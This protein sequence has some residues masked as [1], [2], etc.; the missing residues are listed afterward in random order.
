[1]KQVAS[2]LLNN[3]WKQN[4]ILHMF[5]VLIVEETVTLLCILLVPVG[6]FV[7]LFF[8]FYIHF[9]KLTKKSDKKI[10]NFNLGNFQL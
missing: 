3:M 1:M 10:I 9:R 2:I 5:K 4:T 6:I 7:L 8:G